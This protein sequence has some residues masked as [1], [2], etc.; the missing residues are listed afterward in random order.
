MIGW[1]RYAK[2]MA[3]GAIVLLL[4]I[5]GL[6]A[7]WLAPF[8]PQEQ[9]LEQRLRPPSMDLAENPHV[10]G[11]DNLGRDLLSR[12]I[13]GSRISLMVGAATVFLAGILGC[14]L[15]SGGGI[16]RRDDRRGHQQNHGDLS[17]LPIPA[18]G[19]RHHGLPRDRAW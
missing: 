14:F 5:C 8:D 11:T 4:C 6:G 15:E 18:A 10:M 3:G 13:Y 17:R 12:V 16:L 19:H 9:A 7:P 2:V 1:R